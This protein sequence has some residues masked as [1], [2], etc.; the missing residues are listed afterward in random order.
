MSFNE[1]VTNPVSESQSQ[2]ISVSISSVE[3]EVQATNQEISETR[4]NINT[5]KSQVPVENEGVET[6]SNSSDS[7]VDALSAKLDDLTTRYQSLVSRIDELKSQ[8]ETIEDEKLKASLSKDLEKIEGESGEVL[9]DIGRALGVPEDKLDDYLA[10]NY[11]P[12]ASGLNLADPDSMEAF[13]TFLQN[14][15]EK[16]SKSENDLRAIEKKLGL[17]SISG[18]ENE[19]KK[20]E[21]QAAGGASGGGGSG[22]KSIDVEALYKDFSKLAKSASAEELIDFYKKNKEEL[23]TFIKENLSYSEKKDLVQDIVD[24]AEDIRNRT[25]LSQTEKIQMMDSL[26][27]MLD[28]IPPELKP[29]SSVFN[30]GKSP[31][32]VCKDFSDALKQDDLGTLT[33]I[34]MDDT[35]KLKEGFAKLSPEERTE[36]ISILGQ[37][38]ENYQDD[39]ITSN[40]LNVMLDTLNALN[41]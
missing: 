33:K 32:N 28:G 36:M 40:A 16:L 34:F 1:L 20:E 41:K 13:M 23:D 19:G 22:E 5:L 30:P 4:S 31:E 38:K 8:L 12:N 37:F 26:K 27:S 11:K 3:E 21:A 10:G 24:Q 29:D 35:S 18:A 2:A 6:V 7:I 15:D 39:P 25:D 14:A 17:D 9:K